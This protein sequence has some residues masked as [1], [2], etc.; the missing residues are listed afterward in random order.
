M[1]LVLQAPSALHRV[2]LQ[3]SGH[4]GAEVT[5]CCVDKKE[6]ETV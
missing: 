1:V 4:T 2:N 3:R 6:V 5:R